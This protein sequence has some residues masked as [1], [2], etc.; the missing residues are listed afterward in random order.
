MNA[1]LDNKEILKSLI[2][3]DYD[4][5]GAFAKAK[6]LAHPLLPKSLFKFRGVTD[7]ALDNLRN[8]TLFCAKPKTF[9][10]PFDCA[11]TLKGPDE[12]TIYC[13]TIISLGWETEEHLNLIKNAADPF[14]AL[15]QIAKQQTK[16]TEYLDKHNFRE[17]IEEILFEPIQTLNDK[18]RD[19]CN[20]CSL[21]ERVDSL[22]MWAHYGDDH[23]GF[24][25][26]YDFRKLDARSKLR[27]SIW[28]V[29]YEKKRYDVTQQIF[30]R[31]VKK[32]NELFV[33]G[34]ALSK[35]AD[36]QY[37][38]EW[39]IVKYVGSNTPPSNVKVPAPVA[40]YLGAEITE[41]HSKVLREEAKRKNIPVFRMVLSKDAFKMIPVPL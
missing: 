25:M 7:G 9:N 13:K 39:R 14:G 27:S 8:N 12:R 22:P 10:D 23:C 35:S 33:L 11:L 2:H 38:Q 1:P 21:S 29:L 37:E 18:M 40:L 34:G 41:E 36:W 28:P 30:G 4:K 5:P 26:E 6:K 3:Q 31:P 17:K 15:I 16:L 20:I 24:A 32:F 19:S